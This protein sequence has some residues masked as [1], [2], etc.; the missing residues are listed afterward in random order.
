MSVASCQIYQTAFGNDIDCLAV[1]QLVGFDIVPCRSV[2]HCH[3]LQRGN[4]HFNIEMSC[5]AAD[6]AIFHLHEMVGRD[7]IIAAGHGYE[8]IADSRCLRH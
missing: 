8:D 1:F 4:C 3:L 2:A 7:D 6:C 5:I